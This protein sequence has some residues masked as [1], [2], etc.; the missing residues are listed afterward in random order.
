MKRAD[1]NI[2]HAA[3]IAG[4]ERRSLGKLLKKHGISA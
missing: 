4:K 2:S 3:R 1:G